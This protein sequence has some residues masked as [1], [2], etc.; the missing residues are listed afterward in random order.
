MFDVLDLYVPAL[1]AAAH[2]RPVQRDT[3]WGPAAEVTLYW[4]DLPFAHPL[5]PETAERR[6]T[7]PGPRDAWAGFALAREARDAAASE[8]EWARYLGALRAVLDA[9]ADWLVVVEADG[10]PHPVV[11]VALTAAELTERLDEQRRS[12]RSGLALEVTP[13]RG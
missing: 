1:A 6:A 9:H 3:A 11:P 7:A 5:A 12:P 10:N 4:E 8:V 2:L 13:R